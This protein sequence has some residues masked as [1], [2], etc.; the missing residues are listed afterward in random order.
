MPEIFAL[1]NNYSKIFPLD[2]QIDNMSPKT[3]M[4]KLAFAGPTIV[5]INEVSLI[6]DGTIYNSEQLFQELS[7]EPE[8]EYDYEIIVHLYIRYGIEMTLQMLDGTFAFALVDYRL[9]NGTNSTMYI[10]RDPYGVKPMYLLRPNSKDIMHE[11]NRT[12]GDIYSISSNMNSLKAFETEMNKQ[13]HPKNKGALPK[14]PFYGIDTVL[15]GTYSVFEIKFRVLASWRFMKQNIPYYT[16]NLANLCRGSDE[17]GTPRKMFRN[18]ENRWVNDAV[19]KRI[20]NRDS[21]AVVLT[22]SNESYVIADIASTYKRSLVRGRDGMR[23]IPK[24]QQLTTENTVGG[25]LR[26]LTVGVHSS[27]EDVT[28]Y[29]F[30]DH[31][32]ISQFLAKNHPELS[33]FHTELCMN[34]EDVE[35]EKKN[36]AD[37]WGSYRWWF[38]AKKIAENRPKSLVLLEVGIDEFIDIAYD[39]NIEGVE[40]ERRNTLDRRYNMQLYLKTI[41]DRK[42]RF[43]S[44]I[45]MLQGLDVEYVWLD[46]SLIQHF[47]NT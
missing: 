41:C 32:E 21:I 23:S 44:E 4:I 37:D 19:I 2:H 14:I 5:T 24:P 40:I 38:T 13:Q 20:R 34:E 18:L 43:I 3:V 27:L 28:T 15:P 42:L 1:L 9:S 29:S 30:K 10:A 17:A 39:E 12:D 11:Y 7:I 8:T 22:G 33:T 26:S 6:C 47:I 25:D 31:I 36:L 35:R 46:K 16:Y 45:F